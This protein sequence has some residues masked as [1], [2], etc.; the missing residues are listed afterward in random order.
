MLILRDAFNQIEHCL[1]SEPPCLVASSDASRIDGLLRR[2]LVRLSATT[3]S[4]RIS[5]KLDMADFIEHVEPI[6]C[7]L[8]RFSNGKQ[9]VVSEQG[10]FLLSECFRDI[11]TLVFVEYYA[12]SIE[13]DMVLRN[14]SRTV[15]RSLPIMR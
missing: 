9:A 14:T 13:D 6:D 15:V 11:T 10:C 2:D 5:K 1:P 12:L 4:R 3:A 7:L 8:D